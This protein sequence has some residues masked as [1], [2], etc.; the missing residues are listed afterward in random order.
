MV[1]ASVQL[2][3]P[4]PT[5]AG[6][7]GSFFTGPQAPVQEKGIDQPYCPACNEL[8]IPESKFCGD[9][10]SPA[11]P[12]IHIHNREADHANVSAASM[13][14]SMPAFAQV[15]PQLRKPIPAA[16][17]KEYCK[18]STLLFRERFFLFMHSAVFLTANLFGI[19][20]AFKAHSSFIGDDMTRTVVSVIPL[21]FINSISL[22]CLVPIKGTR[23]EIDKLR[24]RM[25]YLHYQIE[26]IN[27]A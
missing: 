23:K 14:E 10:G 11:S 1:S 2:Q 21:F 13:P 15:S 3:E 4:I 19:W 5:N 7:I 16:L 24:N 6:L 8:L 9:C 12:H 22:G 17:K 25:T 20:V 26:Y 27:L 18:V